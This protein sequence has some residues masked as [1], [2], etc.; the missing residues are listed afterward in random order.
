MTCSSLLLFPS[1][2]HTLPAACGSWRGWRGSGGTG[3]AS[4]AC[5]QV[6]A[7]N[8]VLKKRTSHHQAFLPLFLLCLS[9]TGVSLPSGE[10]GKGC[11]RS[12]G[13][14]TRCPGRHCWGQVPYPTAEQFRVVLRCPRCCLSMLPAVPLC[15]EQRI[16]LSWNTSTASVGETL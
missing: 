6:E 5:A 10:L 9:C 4:A 14:S 8:F 12:S 3:C 13:G 2:A 1:P 16:C 11:W 15:V 7:G